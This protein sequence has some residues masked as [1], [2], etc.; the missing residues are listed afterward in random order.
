M[1]EPDKKYQHKKAMYNV[2]SMR[3]R[4]PK[5]CTDA[6]KRSCGVVGKERDVEGKCHE[7]L[8]LIYIG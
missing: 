7:P 5:L 2:K 4:T 6:A 3:L 1:L 8:T